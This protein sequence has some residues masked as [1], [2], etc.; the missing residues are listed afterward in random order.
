MPTKTGRRLE[1]LG[2]LLDLIS[3]ASKQQVVYMQGLGPVRPDSPTYQLS[4]QD[5]PARDVLLRALALMEPQVAIM[6][7]SHRVCEK[8]PPIHVISLKNREPISV[9]QKLCAAKSTRRREFQEITGLEHIREHEPPRCTTQRGAAAFSNSSVSR[10]SL[11]TSASNTTF[12]GRSP[13]P[14]PSPTDQL[15]VLP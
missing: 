12:T 2:T 15:S 13:K 9:R 11:G 8:N 5:E 4:A 7:E 3:D 14:G 6:S 10:S 1:L